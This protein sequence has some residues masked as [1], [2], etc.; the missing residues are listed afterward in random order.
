[1]L[2]IIYCIPHIIFFLLFSTVLLA[3]FGVLKA[4]PWSGEEGSNV[5]TSTQQATRMVLVIS[6]L[7]PAIDDTLTVSST[8]LPI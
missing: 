5:C 8:L 6:Q 1:M 7:I 3:C 4:I 2:G